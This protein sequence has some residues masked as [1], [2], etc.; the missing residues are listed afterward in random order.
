MIAAMIPRT[1]ARIVPHG[2]KRKRK[3]RFNVSAELN[4][5]GFDWLTC[6]DRPCSQQHYGPPGMD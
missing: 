4:P 2:L 5:R 3:F 1:H 6:Q